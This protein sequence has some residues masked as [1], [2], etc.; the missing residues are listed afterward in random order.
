MNLNARLFAKAP[1]YIYGSFYRNGTVY[2]FCT[3]LLGVHPED[4]GNIK[5]ERICSCK[6]RERKRL[7]TEDESRKESKT[8]M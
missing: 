4:V 2:R 6:S 5:R 8:Q 3:E 7:S 1:G